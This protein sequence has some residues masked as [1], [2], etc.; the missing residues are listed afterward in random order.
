MG[1]LA[2]FRPR[3]VMRASSWATW[4]SWLSPRLDERKGLIGWGLLLG[5]SKTSSVLGLLVQ[6]IRDRPSD[7]LFLGVLALAHGCR[8]I[9]PLDVKGCDESRVEREP[10]GTNTRP[11]VGLEWPHRNRLG[12]ARHVE[13]L[14]MAVSY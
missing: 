11:V 9:L 13:R 5:K 6:R 14:N 7:A 12:G 10:C 3:V 2:T 1:S 8:L 4:S